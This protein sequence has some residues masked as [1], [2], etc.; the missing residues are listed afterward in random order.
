VSYLC[1]GMVSL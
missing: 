1:K